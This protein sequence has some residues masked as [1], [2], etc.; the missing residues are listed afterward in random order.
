MKYS[1]STMS[2]VGTMI[3]LPLA[4][5]R[6]LLV[7]IMRARASTCASTDSGTWTAIWGPSKSGLEAAQARV[8]GP[9]PQEHGFECLDAE[10]VEG[11]R[12]VQQHRMLADDLVEDVPDLGAL[13][14]HHLLRA[15]DG[16]DRGALFE[17]FVD[18]GLE[19]LEGHLLRQAALVQPQLRADDDDRTSRV[20][21]ALAEQ[22]LAEAAAVALQHVGE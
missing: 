5:E 10:A 8:G 21:D 9:S 14:L 22:V 6:M 18:E 15:L 7:D 17:L 3:G 1:P 13:L 16:G 11:G 12:A 2:C 4:G 19:E 20:V